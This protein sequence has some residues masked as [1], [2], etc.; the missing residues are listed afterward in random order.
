MDILDRILKVQKLSHEL[1][2]AIKTIC[3]I[4]A[5]IKRELH[6]IQYNDLPGIIRDEINEKE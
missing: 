5:Q 6:S 4:E 2:C 1:E 3:D